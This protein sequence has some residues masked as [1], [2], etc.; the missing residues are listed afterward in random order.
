MR[1]G[2]LGASNAEVDR[3]DPR[4]H[5]PCPPPSPPSTQRVPKLSR[6]EGL[7]L[8]GLLDRGGPLEGAVLSTRAIQP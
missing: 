4:H 6:R 8:L 3:G 2:L 5:R 7:D 1:G